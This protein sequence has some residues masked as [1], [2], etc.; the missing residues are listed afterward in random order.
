MLSLL[1]LLVLAPVVKEVM[2]MAVVA[3]MVQ[4]AI[5]MHTSGI[6]ITSFTTGASTRST[7]SDSIGCG[8]SGRPPSRLNCIWG[9]CRQHFLFEP[10][11]LR[12]PHCTT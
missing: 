3:A 5:E 11:P 7:R 10:Q 8:C 6:T 2:V 1:V 9:S 12:I 4:M